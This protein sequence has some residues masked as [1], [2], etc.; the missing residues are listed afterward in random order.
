[1]DGRGLPKQ[2]QG[3][4]ISPAN[5]EDALHQLSGA[6]HFLEAARRRILG[7]WIVGFVQ[8]HLQIPAHPGQGRAQLVCQFIIGALQLSGQGQHL[9]QPRIDHTGKIAQFRDG[10]RGTQAGI[11]LGRVQPFG[12]SGEAVD[13]RQHHPPIPDPGNPHQ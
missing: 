9:I 5:G 4:M 3:P 6:V 1:M 11:A 7:L 12:T 2:A 10:S 13:R 8:H